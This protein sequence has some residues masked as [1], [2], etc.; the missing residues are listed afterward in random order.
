MGQAVEFHHL[1]GGVTNDAHQAVIETQFLDDQGNPIDL[2]TASGGAVTSVTVTGLA[3][4]A[5]PT[6]TLAGGVLALGIPAGAKGDTGAVGAPGK[7]GAN[8]APGAAG[9][10]VKSI[11]LTTDASGKVTGGTLTKTDNTT[12][13]IT[14]TVAAA[15]G[16]QPADQPSAVQ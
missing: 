9:L 4:G 12:A 11:A 8:G 16:D 3:A 14:V 2:G 7:A 15:A 13:A 1:A 6:A 5:K 10:G